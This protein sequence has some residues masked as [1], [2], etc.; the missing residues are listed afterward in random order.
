MQRGVIVDVL[1]SAVM[2][3]DEDKTDPNNPVIRHLVP[4][5]KLEFLAHGENERIRVKALNDGKE[6]W[7]T[8]VHNDSGIQILGVALSEVTKRMPAKNCK[9][10]DAVAG[11]DKTIAFRKMDSIKLD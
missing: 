1:H 7:V 10:G 9:S 2:R 11:S 5:E 6:G 8:S 3:R 4:G